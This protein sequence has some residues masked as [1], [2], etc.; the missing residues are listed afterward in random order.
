[1]KITKRLERVASH[2]SKGSIVLDIGTDHGYIPV[3]LVKKG[4]SPSAIAADVNKKPLDKAKELIAEN[5]MNDKVETRLGSGFE[6]IKDGEVDEVIIA[7]MGGV[8]I[9]DLITAA[10]EI[11]KKLKKLVLQPMQAQKELRKYLLK[12]GYEIIEEELV[13]EDG[14]IFEIIVVEYKG[15]DFSDGMEE[16]D[17]EISKKHRNQNN[18]L[19]IEF[20]E[21]KI[22]EEE[23]ILEKIKGKETKE[24]NEKREICKKRL[25]VLRGLLEN[26]IKGNN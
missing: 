11:P 26:E 8:L 4:V 2:I 10:G 13:K 12:N 23:S 6:I 7:G 18:P 1:M 19:F 14:R 3:F 21:R 16:I 22:H 24:V 20:L 17:F 15:Q 9:S 5:K 25:E